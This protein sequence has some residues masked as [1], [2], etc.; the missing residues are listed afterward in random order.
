MKWNKYTW[1]SRWAALVVFLF[2][3]PAWTF[4]LGTQY[5]LTKMIVE[6]DDDVLFVYT[7]PKPRM[8]IEEY[9]RDAI[10]TL[11][12]IKEQTGGKFYVTKITAVEGRGIVQYEDGHNAYNAFFDYALSTSTR[13]YIITNFSVED[14]N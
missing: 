5:E 12:P 9:V 3:L 1:Y 2:I 4:Y 6:K 13:S 7:P 11:S 14:R 8:T 10:S